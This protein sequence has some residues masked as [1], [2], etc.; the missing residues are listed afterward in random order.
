MLTII[1]YYCY[2][3][4]HIHKSVFIKQFFFLQ[5]HQNHIFGLEA[6]IH[7]KAVD[8]SIRLEY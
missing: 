4:I 2:I 3:L 7:R 6:T 5:Q 8:G 1:L